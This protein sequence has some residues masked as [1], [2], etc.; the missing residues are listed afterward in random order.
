MRKLS[1]EAVHCGGVHEVG[2]PPALQVV[3][4]HV[5]VVLQDLPVYELPNLGQPSLSMPEFLSFYHWPGCP[6]AEVAYMT[7]PGNEVKQ[8]PSCMPPA[9]W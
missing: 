1:P 5:R 2:L 4:Q 3:C 9:S 7:L 8:L 6:T